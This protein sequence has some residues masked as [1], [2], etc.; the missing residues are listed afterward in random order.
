[1][2]WEYITREHHLIDVENPDKR[3]TKLG[4][5]GWELVAVVLIPNDPPRLVYYLKRPQKPWDP[6]NVLR[7]TP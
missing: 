7:N 3:L 1:M 2:R 5:D 6:T 4:D